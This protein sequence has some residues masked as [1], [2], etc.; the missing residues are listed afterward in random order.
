M[1]SRPKPKVSQFFSNS[2]FQRKETPCISKRSLRSSRERTIQSRSPHFLLHSP[3]AE[4]M[5]YLDEYSYS[6]AQSHSV[7]V[8][9]SGGDMRTTHDPQNPTVKIEQSTFETSQPNMFSP[10]RTRGLR[11]RTSRSSTGSSVQ[12]SSTKRASWKSN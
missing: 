3:H 6:T 12:R 10:S 5:W 7:L 4:S 11:R 2:Y 1:S 8:L 9:Q